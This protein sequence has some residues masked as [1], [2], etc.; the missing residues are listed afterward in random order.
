MSI[1]MTQDQFKRLQE[2][3]GELQKRTQLLGSFI[4]SNPIY[5]DLGVEEN[6]RLNLQHYHMTEYGNILRARLQAQLAA[7]I[8]PNG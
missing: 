7:G 3:Q 1:R 2:E 8:T 4:A 5:K 6:V